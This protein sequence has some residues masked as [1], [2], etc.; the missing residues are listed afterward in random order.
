M[1][2]TLAMSWSTWY[3]ELLRNEKLINFTNFLQVYLDSHYN[4]VW[5]K[6][7]KP[8]QNKSS[9]EFLIKQHTLLFIDSYFL[10]LFNHLL[11]PNYPFFVVYYKHIKR[12]G[13]QA[14]LLSATLRIFELA[15][16]TLNHVNLKY[17]AFSEVLLWLVLQSSPTG[18][19]KCLLLL[20]HTSKYHIV[21]KYEAMQF[22]II[23]KECR[24]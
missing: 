1:L 23:K 14:Y 4:Y 16:C 8:T 19:H 11:S 13:R 15:G 7:K 12:H 20:S 6:Q 10:L 17:S 24:S 5:R 3:T 22:Q 9:P 2:K 18:S 21:S